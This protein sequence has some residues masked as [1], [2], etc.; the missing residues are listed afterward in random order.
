MEICE[1]IHA[2]Y[3]AGKPEDVVGSYR[4]LSL[5]SY[6][7][8][9]LE[10]AVA[11][12]LSNWA[13][14]NK[15][16]NKQ[17]NGFRKSR[18]TNDNLFK[19]FETVKLGFC[20]DHPTTGIFTDVKKAFD[21]VWFDGHLFKLISVGLNR[22]LIRWISNFLNQRKLTIS[23]NDQLTDP[24]TSCLV[25]QGSHLPPIL[26]YASNI[27][28]P[29]DAQANLS[30]FVD[31]VTIWTQAPGIRNINLRLQK[32]LNQILTWCDR[33]RI[34][35]NPGITRLINFSQRNVITDSSI[36]MSGQPLK[37]TDSVK[38]LGFLY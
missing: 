20:K 18:S 1:N 6:L 3:K 11:D 23:I 37:V 15:K 35:L 13:E 7:G 12:T 30:Q 33:W 21:Q 17:Q 26:L 24:I 10:K 9:F 5:T 16:F 22:K 28:Q 27:P 36:T 25:G 29:L 31:D 14:A 38:F 8:K 32:Y 19:L 4:P 2:T 34:K